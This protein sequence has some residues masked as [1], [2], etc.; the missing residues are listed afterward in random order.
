MALRGLDLGMIVSLY[1]I[2][3]RRTNETIAQVDIVVDVVVDASFSK[4]VEK[5]KKEVLCFWS[6][7]LAIKKRVV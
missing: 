2:V 7:I 3:E 4:Q 1:D 5:P 6:W